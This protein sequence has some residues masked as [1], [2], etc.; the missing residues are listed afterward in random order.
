MLYSIALL[1]LLVVLVIIYTPVYCI[2]QLWEAAEVRKRGSAACNSQWS[3]Q[4]LRVDR[5]TQTSDRR[6]EESTA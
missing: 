1:L 6:G 2:L 5:R 3:H 4:L